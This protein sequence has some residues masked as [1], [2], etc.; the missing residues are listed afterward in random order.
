MRRIVERVARRRNGITAPR[1]KSSG[2]ASLA[3][4]TVIITALDGARKAVSHIPTSSEE[5]VKSSS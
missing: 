1:R 4:L 5:K 2:T 3:E